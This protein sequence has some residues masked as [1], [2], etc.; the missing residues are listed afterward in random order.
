MTAGAAADSP[1]VDAVPQARQDL[2]AAL[3]NRP[4]DPVVAVMAL[5]DGTETT[6][7]LVPYGV[8]KRAGIGQVEAVAVEAGDVTLMPALRIVPDTTLTAFDA[9]YPRGADVVIVPAMH[10]DNDPRVLQWLQR[11][12]ANGALIVG[13]CSGA[14]VLSQAGLLREKRFAGHWYDRDDL[15][16]DNPTARYVSDVRYLYDDG[17]VTTTGVSASLPLSLALV[18]GIAGEKRAADVARSL[19]VTDWSA[20]HA[21]AGFRL[22]AS[23]L[24]TIASHWLAFWRHETLAIPVS[25]GVDDVSLALV[26]DAWSRTWRSE[27]IAVHEG[28]RTVRMASGLRL[29][30][31][32]DISVTPV[33]TIALASHTSAMANFT[34]AL[35][36]IGQRYG[37]STRDL[38]ALSLE[39]PDGLR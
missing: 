15:R 11:Q 32:M 17:I 33:R 35:D 37:A 23:R 20:R 16:K 10:V 5:N 24:W 2:L 7:F 14:K 26:S 13:I 12:A 27:A 39:Y 31:Q 21:S 29:V 22:D 6:D 9:R 36:A 3:A 1:E 38:V 19:G 4:K 28:T 30:P 25:D 34:A 8:L 18:E